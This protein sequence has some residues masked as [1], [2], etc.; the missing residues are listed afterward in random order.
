V[1]EDGRRRPVGGRPGDET[2]D[3]KPASSGDQPQQQ[4]G[5]ETATAPAVGGHER[6]VGGAGETVEPGDGHDLAIRDSD[7][8]SRWT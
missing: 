3:A 6:D 7:F 5:A 2:A 4:C 1:A 8:A